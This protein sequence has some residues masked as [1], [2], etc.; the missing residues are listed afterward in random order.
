MNAIRVALAQSRSDL[1]AG[2]ISDA[3]TK[4]P[5]FELVG[6][7]V[8][9]LSMIGKVLSA[10]LDPIDVLIIVGDMGS[11]VLD[12][13]LARH[14]GIVVS[15]IVIGSDSIRFDLRS[16]GVDQLLS[17]LTTLARN[18]KTG[19]PREFAFQAVPR[20]SAR[21][22]SEFG[23]VP[24]PA[25]SELMKLAVAWIDA[26]LLHY[27]ERFP[28]AAGDV[29]GLV[30]H[31][32][33]LKHLLAPE[34]R[35]EESE[36]ARRAAERLLVALVSAG[37][38]DEPLVRL[39]RRL[40]LSAL[41]LKVLLLCLAP[42]LDAKY[43]AAFGILNDDL[44]RRGPSLG[45]A[46]KI[47]GESSVVRAT[48]TQAGKLTRWQLL[49]CGA[50]LPRADEVM[51]L[52][53]ALA[54]WLLGDAGALLHDPAVRTV[55][56][57][58]PWRGARLLGEAFDQGLAGQL[59]GALASDANR[60]RWVI[61]S[62]ADA[63]GWRAIA[64]LAVQLGGPPLLRVSLAT[65]ANL[66]DSE[67]VGTA[68]RLARA[69]TLLGASPV[70]D[71]RDGDS[72]VT[73]EA[74]VAMLASM[75][76]DLSQGI[77]LITDDA[78]RFAS[79]LHD[80]VVAVLE[81][82]AP[83][84]PA[85]AATFR[86]AA[87]Q[88][89][90]SLTDEACMRL[91]HAFP[92]PPGVIEDAVRLAAL[93]GAAGL[94]APSQYARVAAACR[95]ISSPDMPRF[96]KR[97]VPTFALDDIVLP[98]EWHEQL[99]ELVNNVVHAPKV[100]NDWGFG[101]TLP[102]G[103]G[104]AALFHGPSGTG[105]TTAAQAVARALD[106][107]V[108]QA[109]LSLLESKFIGETAKNVDMLFNDAER[110]HAVLVC[111]EADAI[112]GKRSEIK[113]AHDRYANIDV[114]YLLQRIEAYSGLV[115]LTTNFRQN[116]D[117]AFQRRFRFVVEFPKPDVQGREQIWRKCLPGSAPVGADVDF[118]FLARRVELTG[119]NI[120]QIA[121][122]AAF[123]AA[124]DHS[125]EIT[126]AHILGAT[127]AELLKIGMTTAARELDDLAALRRQGLRQVA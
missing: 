115:I 16:V 38:D 93:Q 23:F 34:P 114:A 36:E 46:C 113:D 86:T 32:A 127:R 48:L 117:Q 39:H 27:Q 65:F 51:R 89:E 78:R 94:P 84:P 59:A 17:T 116:I 55:L 61:L 25:N 9:D 66:P 57:S 100:M 58:A 83:L 80:R 6:G 82:D 95:H 50:Q 76:K 125:P 70:I 73:C 72:R 24:M 54:G 69:A 62:G 42:D 122:R 7:D 60:G 53:S 19:T 112:L 105:K 20:P 119:G 15:Y 41:E 33:S 74:A 101:A 96:A 21:L 71:V 52:D 87:L 8:F 91:A 22:E 68:A 40:S 1:L 118:G 31:P 13:Q 18:R 30:R 47:L 3:L 45:L 111:D 85:I 107:D 64:E 92:Q 29:A 126:M 77:A 90:L 10:S 120:R 49:D 35:V 5:E 106:T 12:D 37:N 81:R 104:I 43:Q 79:L 109:D 102:Q 4:S 88:S 99:R 44:S 56:E 14:P 97:I 63:D 11:V 98:A 103:R 110:S 26:V 108:Y 123:A 67:A 75:L 124:A 121:L 28:P 2:L